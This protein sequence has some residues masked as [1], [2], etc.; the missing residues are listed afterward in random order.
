MTSTSDH[1]VIELRSAA[2]W[3]R[4]PGRAITFHADGVTAKLD[5]EDRLVRFT[6]VGEGSGSMQLVV[7]VASADDRVSVVTEKSGQGVLELAS[8]VD[9]AVNDRQDDGRVTSTL[10]LF[11]GREGGPQSYAG[12]PND[13]RPR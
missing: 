10:V 9:R 5:I 2:T 12:T 3:A 6:R 1:N 11:L 4:G 13:H 8:D 7:Q